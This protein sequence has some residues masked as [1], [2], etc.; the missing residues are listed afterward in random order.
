MEPYQEN[1]Y[2]PPQ[3]ELGTVPAQPLEPEALR[4]IPFED[5]EEYPTLWLRFKETI[6]QAVREKEAFLERVPVYD[7][8]TRPWQF[9]M[10]SLVPL[11]GLL[12]L[13][14]ILIGLVALFAGLGSLGSKEGS[15]VIGIAALVL[16]GFAILLPLGTFLGMLLVGVMD[17]FCLWIWGGTKEGVGLPQTIRASGYA[18]GVMNL[19][20]TPL[21]ILGMIPLLG[22]LFSLANMV[23]SVLFIVY[24]GMALA[25]MHRTETWRGVCAVFTPV[26]LMIIL[27]VAILIPMIILAAK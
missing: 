19:I 20:T 22:I 2:L 3:A 27:V 1:P 23:L 17:H 16:V 8:F 4:P 18:H 11:F 14:G 13:V 25:R 12:L 21:Q 10:L 7:D 6:V 9:Q 15:M 26:V 24:K 5:P